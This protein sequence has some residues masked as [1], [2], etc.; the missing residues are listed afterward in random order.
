M[1]N[2]CVIPKTQTN[3]IIPESGRL[4]TYFAQQ[5]YLCRGSTEVFKYRKLIINCFTILIF[6]SSFSYSFPKTSSDLDSFISKMSLEEKI[7]QMFMIGGVGPTD[8]KKLELYS[9]YHYGNVFLGSVD[10]KKLS[11]QNV[12]KL[13]KKLQQLAKENN[14]QIPML[15]S[16]DQ[17]GGMVNRLKKGFKVSPSAQEVGDTQ[18][19][20]QAEQTARDVAAQMIKLGVNVNFSPCIDVNTNN[21][22]HVALSSRTFSSDPVKV[23]EFG[24]AYLRGYSSKGV[25]GT[26]KHF[27]GYGDVAPDP[28]KHLPVSQKTY[29]ELQKCELY[30]Y[31][32][33]INSGIVDMIMTA[34]IGLPKLD[35]DEIIPATFSKNILTGLLRNKIGYKGVIVTDDF[36]MGA[37]EETKNIEQKAL[38]SVDAGV[39]I[40]LFVGYS[41]RWSRVW[42]AIYKAVQEGTIPESR[43][44]ESVKRIL[45]LKQ[46]YNIK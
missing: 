44:N 1:K 43:I 12:G 36:N 25:I 16:T 9:K 5:M 28:H 45:L 19:Y 41:Q 13:T 6:L 33:C 14:N 32:N 8:L 21:K 17:E 35:N 27:P 18:T 15:I 39:D 38:K 34:H 24:A 4:I 7:G 23:A 42:N 37:I 29:D 26:L 22:S 40:I 31:I 11:L 10:L 20:S 2:K 30:P 46:K 3:C